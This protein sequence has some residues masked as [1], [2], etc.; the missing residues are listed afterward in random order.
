MLNVGI[1][2]D[3]TFSK[4]GAWNAEQH[5]LESFKISLAEFNTPVYFK[6]VYRKNRFILRSK[7][8]YNQNIVEIQIGL[9]QKIIL[10]LMRYYLQKPRGNKLIVFY[11]K[12][13]IIFKKSIKLTNIDVIISFTPSIWLMYF[14]GISSIATV[15]DLGFMK[16]PQLKEFS[17]KKYKNLREITLIH[18]MNFA[19]YILTESNALKSELI[20]LYGRN[21]QDIIVTPFVP[22]HLSP[23]MSIDHDIIFT[24]EEFVIYPAAAWS[25]KNHE[26]LF[27]A[28]HNLITNNIKV[29]NLVL[30]G[31]DIDKDKSIQQYIANY[32]IEKYVRLIGLVDEANLVSLYKSCSLLVMPTLLGPTNLPPLEAILFGKPA[33][34]SNIHQFDGRLK[35]FFIYIDPYDLHAWA[36]CFDKNYDPI[37]PDSLEVGKIYKSIVK[38]N[39]LKY[40]KI[41]SNINDKKVKS[42]Y[43]Y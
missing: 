3:S 1:I 42:T 18:A 6:I 15:W 20:E 16:Y 10:R 4:K 36:K 27:K 40:S 39:I 5:C 17:N 30:V 33:C 9:F 43:T 31:K 19:T 25:H 22:L 8:I 29:R 34:I 41:I 28:L 13:L 11:L 2:V 37:R 35:N 32:K 26:I 24:K 14:E 7:L 12:K 38:E 23:S 21:S